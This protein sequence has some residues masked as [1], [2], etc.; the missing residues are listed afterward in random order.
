[1]ST[2]PEKHLWLP[3]P[4]GDSVS[5]GRAFMEHERRVAK[6]EGYRTLTI[7]LGRWLRAP[8][9]SQDLLADDEAVG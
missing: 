6:E 9:L 5:I 8:A 1:M 4:L 2:Y 7:H 3:I